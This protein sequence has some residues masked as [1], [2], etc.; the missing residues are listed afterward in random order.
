[1][2]TTRLVDAGTTP[3]LLKMVESKHLDAKKLISHR[4]KLTEIL[5]APSDPSALDEANNEALDM[6]SKARRQCL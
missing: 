5:K 3:M 4:F 2:L 1:M 6:L